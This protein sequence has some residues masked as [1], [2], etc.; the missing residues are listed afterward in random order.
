MASR[1]KSRVD[2]LA[3]HLD[4]PPKPFLELNTPFSTERSSRL[5]DDNGKRI[6]RPVPSGPRTDHVPVRQIKANPP[7]SPQ[8]PNF[9][10]STE[11]APKSLPKTPQSP[12]QPPKAM[13]TQAAHPALLIPGPIEFHDDVLSSMSHYR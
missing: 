13:S 10:K 9:A 1:A 8:T 11:S 5:E 6:V 12:K 3:K 2:Q 7:K 4:S